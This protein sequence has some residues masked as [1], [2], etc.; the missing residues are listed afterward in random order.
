MTFKTHSVSW[1]I[2]RTIDMFDGSVFMAK[3][4]IN[5]AFIASENSN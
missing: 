3:K 2:V 5:R 4:Y 1:K